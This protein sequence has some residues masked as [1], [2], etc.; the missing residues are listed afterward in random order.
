MTYSDA[1]RQ[2]YHAYLDNASILDNAYDRDTQE[3]KDWEEGWWQ[4]AQDD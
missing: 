2:G 4:A 3:F 1:F